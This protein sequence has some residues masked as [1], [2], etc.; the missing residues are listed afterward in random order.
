[1]ENE[2]PVV[3][4]VIVPV[5]NIF[6]YL[7]RCVDSIR[8]QTY[9]Y[10]DIILVDD[11]STDR[12]GA[13][14][15]KMALED[16]RIRVFHK[17]NGGSSSARNFGLSRAKGEYI[18]FVDSDDY[19]EPQMYEHL[20]A[21][22][23][24]ENLLMVQCSRDEIDENG[25]RMENVCEPPEEAEICNREYFMRELLMHRGDCSFCTKLTHASLFKDKRFPEGELN[26]DFHLLVQLLS[27]VPSIAILPEQDYHVFYR[28]GSNTR[29]KKQDDFPQVYTDIVK[30]ADWVQE[31][32][33]RVSV[34]YRGGH[35]LWIVPTV[36]LYAAYSDLHDECRER[37]LYAGE[38]ISSQASGRC[39]EES[40]S[41]EKEQTIF[42]SSGNST[43]TCE[44]NSLDAEKETNSGGK[45]R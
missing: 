28:Y 33:K 43:K 31:I 26:E 42:A 44:E 21:A 9:P 39:K 10:L 13:L 7:P 35:A 1:M 8:K 36:G 16:T 25:N 4:S 24:Q 15:E 45:I 14:A 38:K 17:E 37:V 29:T 27:E 19:I 12:T 11:G 23:L 40:V 18:G 32:V 20:L 30:N 5:Y 6:E 2:K 22:A 41:Y 3:I 34:A